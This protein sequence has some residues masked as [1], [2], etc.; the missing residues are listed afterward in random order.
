MKQYK[1]SCV[2]QYR[3][4]STPSAQFVYKDHTEYIV[5]QQYFCQP[6]ILLKYNVFCIVF[7][8]KF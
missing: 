6:K 3:Y 4:L 2:D 1:K 7:V 5:F 8:H